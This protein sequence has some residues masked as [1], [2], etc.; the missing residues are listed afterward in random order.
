[1]RKM[2][3][4][5]YIIDSDAY[6]WINIL[7]TWSWLLPENY[8][9][10]L[11]NCFGDLFLILQDGSVHVLL[12]DAGELK[13]LASSKD[14][15]TTLIER[16][17]NA[18]EWLLIPL[19]DRLVAAGKLLRP[20][21]CYS[22]QQLPILGGTYDIDNISERAIGEYLSWLGSVYQQFAKL[23]DGRRVRFKLTD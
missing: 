16:S 8:R 18:K 2:N 14:E 15:F 22:Y 1:M 21:H 3:H 19:V 17:Q 11:L 5:K 23:P 12:T 4:E 9:V 7:M 10:W 13:R 6:H 20:G